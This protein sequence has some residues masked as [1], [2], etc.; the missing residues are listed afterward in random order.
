MEKHVN[1]LKSRF[2][3]WLEEWRNSH[4]YQ[5]TKLERI[6]EHC[7]CSID[8]KPC[9]YTYD[10][11]SC[12]S[13]ANTY[14]MPFDW[15]QEAVRQGVV[16]EPGWQKWWRPPAHMLEGRRYEGVCDRP[17]FGVP[18]GECA[19]GRRPRSPGR[20]ETTPGARDI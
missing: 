8:G 11:E 16:D 17:M 19:A 20:T 3:D 4:D 6:S 7:S 9:G 2:D 18:H 14:T 13:Y 10:G 1:S 15:L 5:Q 12:S